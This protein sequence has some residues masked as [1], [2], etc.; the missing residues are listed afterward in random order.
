[1]LCILCA[2]ICI[3]NNAQAQVLLGCEDP[4]IQEARVGLVDE[5]LKRFNGE[6]S[7]PYISEQ[8]S[9]YR[10]SNILYLIERPQN[11]G[12][13]DSLYNE[14]IKFVDAIINSSVHLNYSDS[15]WIARATCIGFLNDK[16]VVFD[17]YLNVE[18]RK[19]DMYKWVISSVNGKC[20]DTTPRD[21]A[22]NIMLYPDDHEIEF[23]SLGKMTKEQPYNVSRFMSKGFEYDATSAF[24]YLVKSDKLKIEYVDN[25]E[26]IFTQIPGYIFSIKYFERESSKLGWLIN[27]FEVISPEQKI[28]FLQNLNIDCNELISE[29]ESIETTTT[30]NEKLILNKDTI[31]CFANNNVEKIFLSRIAERKVLVKD[32]MSILNQ[33]REKE[34]IEYYQKK[35][36]DLF[37]V[38]SDVYIYNLSND[39]TTKMS[40]TD[41]LRKI[42]S[43]KVEIISMDKITV[44]MWN[45]KLMNIDESNEIKLRSKIELFSVNPTHNSEES[46]RITVARLEQTEDGIEW[47]PY[48]GCIYVTIK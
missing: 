4:L 10:K 42:S 12:N 1:M 30:V 9:C 15:T 28:K 34:V 14:S 7:H 13:K 44:P 22:S 36:L 24:V 43:H 40:I 47:I 46:E 23:I 48:F 37:D 31:N 38:K 41:F 25:L 32:F 29:K 17:V 8:D 11:I 19:E 3:V 33:A 18:C 35:L 39:K 20:F 16:K 26:F 2:F 45:D 6:T 21:T 5:F 27:Q